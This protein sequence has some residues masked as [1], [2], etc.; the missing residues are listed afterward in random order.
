VGEAHM[1]GAI[2]VIGFLYGFTN[3]CSLVSYGLGAEV[4]DDNWLRTGVR[5]DGVIY[6]C[7]SFSTKLGNALGGSVGILILGA[8]GFV[9]NTEMSSSVLTKMN[10]VINFG[11][12]ICFLLSAVFFIGVHMTNKKAKE[13]EALIEQRTAAG[14]M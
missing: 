8:V 6:S 12:A 9:A 5:S 14:E 11:P 4:I 1:S 7:I 3:M 13:N 10:A 2:V